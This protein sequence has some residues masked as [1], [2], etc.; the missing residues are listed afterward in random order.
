M[1]MATHIFPWATIILMVDICSSLLGV[2][3]GFFFC[4]VFVCCL[5][6]FFLNLVT[7]STPFSPLQVCIH[8]GSFI[9]ISN[10]QKSMTSCSFQGS[11]PS[12]YGTELILNG[13]VKCVSQNT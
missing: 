6:G 8:N 2:C 11:E 1:L 5:V 10:F 7:H 3:G 4:C 12:S 9:S 13:S